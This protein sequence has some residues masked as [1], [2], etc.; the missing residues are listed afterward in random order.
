MIPSNTSEETE[1][2]TRHHQIPML[3][4]EYLIK[5]IYRAKPWQMAMQ[6]A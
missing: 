6:A 3:L 1:K 4:Q 2:R 5:E